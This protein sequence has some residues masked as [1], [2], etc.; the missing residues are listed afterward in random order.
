L[1]RPA[2]TGEKVTGLPVAGF[3]IRVIDRPIGVGGLAGRL[4]DRAVGGG[5]RRGIKG[6]IGQ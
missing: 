6:S 1:G 5:E 3:V 2:T 4:G